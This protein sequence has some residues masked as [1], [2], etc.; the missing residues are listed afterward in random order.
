MLPKRVQVLKRALLHSVSCGG[1]AG[2]T[3]NTVQDLMENVAS[4]EEVLLQ[5]S[6]SS[7]IP[8]DSHD[9]ADHYPNNLCHLRIDETT[10]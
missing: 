4:L 9:P 10:Q 5:M 1:E 3:D 6:A 2:D 7:K 8:L